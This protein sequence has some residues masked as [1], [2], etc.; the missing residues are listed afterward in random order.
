MG[1][2]AKFSTKPS[3]KLAAAG[4]G[5]TKVSAGAASMAAYGRAKTGVDIGAAL[6]DPDD[7]ATIY[8]TFMVIFYGFFG[9]T[10]LFYP[11][12]HAASYNP[13][14]YWTSMTDQ[15][16]FS[17][18]IAGSTMLAIVLGPFL[19]EIFGGPGGARRSGPGL[20]AVVSQIC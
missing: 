6:A 16:A 18:R 1:F 19:D 7:E 2:L 20:A 5:G 3:Q 8:T 9:L 17:F 4:P 15:L 12:I 13:M 11:Y 14:A 10:L